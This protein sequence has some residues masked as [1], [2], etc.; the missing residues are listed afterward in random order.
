MTEGL[1]EQILS[2]G[3][4]FAS[5]I[6]GVVAVLAGGRFY[7]IGRRRRRM[8][9]DY[10]K[11]QSSFDEEYTFGS[12][13]RPHGMRTVTHLMAKLAMTDAQVLDAVFSSKKI[14]R[15]LSSDPKTGY[16]NEM[17]FQYHPKG[18]TESLDEMVARVL[19]AVKPK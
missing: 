15:Y 10:L 8:L 11:S 7:L 9:E 1:V 6:T 3:S 12:P 13:G 2:A 16:A 14:R 5:I 18:G 17:L 4:N 19:A